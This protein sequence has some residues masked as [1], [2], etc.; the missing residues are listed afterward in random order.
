MSSKLKL[1]VLKT[2]SGVIV[3][4]DDGQPRYFSDKMQA[5]QAR[6]EDMKVSFGPDH[7][8]FQGAN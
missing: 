2:K 3:R 8:R 6:T 4:G 1:F 5:K 7:K